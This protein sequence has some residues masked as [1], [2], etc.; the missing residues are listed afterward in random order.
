MS[1]LYHW[2]IKGQKWGV[3]RYQNE[4][5][6]LTPEGRAHYQRIA[7]VKPSTSTLGGAVGGAAA[8]GWNHGG[9]I[10]AVA[11]AAAGAL[12]GY[13]AYRVQKH[14]YDKANKKLQEDNKR[15]QEE[16]ENSDEYKEYL[17]KLKNEGKRLNDGGA[18]SFQSSKNKDAAL[19]F[20]EARWHES[21]WAKERGLNSPEKV[22]DYIKQS[23][24]NFNENDPDQV[25]YQHMDEVSTMLE[26][27]FISKKT[28]DKL[29][30]AQL[31]E[32]SFDFANY[33]DT[34]FI[35]KWHNVGSATS[36]PDQSYARYGKNAGK[37]SGRYTTGSRSWVEEAANDPEHWELIDNTPGE[38]LYKRRDPPKSSGRYT[39]GSKP[40][41]NDWKDLG[42]GEYS[43]TKQNSKQPSGRYVQVV[44]KNGTGRSMVRIN[45]KSS[46]AVTL[47]Y[48]GYSRSEIA[49]ILGI[50]EDSLSK[51][52][53]SYKGKTYNGGIG[54]GR[55]SR[56]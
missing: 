43:P 41:P 23:L 31:A 18:S 44:N 52:L 6:S 37:S 27:G 26:K 3:R 46:A 17:G 36:K 45:D 1:E 2:G 7:N 25:V 32:D 5:G 51:E 42:G 19:G 16:Y 33:G 12:G 8:V 9:V 35:D 48:M 24:K 56:K 10:G 22:R 13:A 15:R 11:G 40:D 38:R 30:D 4:D 29:Y 28:F 34:D 20:K 49:K 21:D 50:S 39:T 53:S 55:I 47:G 14:G 54:I